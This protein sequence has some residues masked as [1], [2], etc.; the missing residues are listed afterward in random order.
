MEQLDSGQIHLWLAWLG[1]ITD[2]RLLAEYRSLLSEEELAK[3]ARF[4]FE[5]DQH[6]YLVTRAMVRMVLSKYAQVAPCDWRFSINEHGKPSIAAEHAGGARG[7][8]FNLSHTDALVALG[9]TRGRAIGVDVEDARARAVGLDIA[10]RFFALA[11][12]AALRALPHEQQQRRFFD[13]WTLKE[14]Y[15]K[16][17]GGGMSIPLGSF[18]FFLEDP[19]RIRL[20]IDESLQDRAERWLFLRFRF[21]MNHLVALCSEVGGGDRPRLRVASWT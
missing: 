11:E 9:V 6:R 18:A 4:H 17:R 19:A 10:D 15:V 1:E 21:R 14:S 12:A 7:M 5:R 13:Y 3:Q 16:A 20:E 2:P 8:Q